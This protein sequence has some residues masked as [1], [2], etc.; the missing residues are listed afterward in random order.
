LKT[1]AEKLPQW[2]G[3]TDLHFHVSFVESKRHIRLQICDLI[4]GAAGSYG[5]KMH[6]KRP[7]RARGMSDKQKLKLEISK[8]IYAKLK[9][10]VMSQR[11]S[12][13][14]NW[15]ETTGVDGNLENRL[16]HKIRIWKFIPASHKIDRGWQNDHLDSH[17]DYQGPDIIDPPETEEIL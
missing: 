7:N 6:L 4:M 11:H 12:R 9:A 17:G 10:I 1:S 16:A 14:F 5:N 13:A 2:L 15:F 8:Y 3:R